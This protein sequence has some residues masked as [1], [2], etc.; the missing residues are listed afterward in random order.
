MTI[1]RYLLLTFT[2]C[3]I[4]SNYN[5][6]FGQTKI[7]V[8]PFPIETVFLHKI[9]NTVLI[10]QALNDESHNKLRE[11]NSKWQ[12]IRNQSQ[13][14]EE[15]LF[16][17]HILIDQRLPN[18]AYPKTEHA[19]LAISGYLSWNREL[20]RALKV[21]Q[22]EHKTNDILLEEIR[23]NLLLGN[24]QRVERNL[25]Q[26]SPKT[27]EEQLIRQIL[28]YWYLM[29]TGNIDRAEK[30]SQSIESEYL[31]SSQFN[32]HS[33]SFYD[34]AEEKVDLYQKA[35]TRFPSNEIIFE[36]LLKKLL[37]GRKYCDIQHLLKLQASIYHLKTD[38]QYL[39]N[40]IDKC[41]NQSSVEIKVDYTYLSWQAAQAL[42]KTQYNH[43]KQ[44]AEALIR[45]YPEYL[46]GQ[47]F[48]LEYYRETGQIELK[49][50]LQET[51]NLENQNHLN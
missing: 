21:L 12:K 17:N 24:Y 22:I 11:A 42:K 37:Q 30:V 34:K 1:S 47:L 9:E 49:Q 2:S 3:L 25:I 43:L 18:Q 13:K 39:N 40:M 23:L 50:K 44:Y 29:L 5:L 41:L 6:T 51:I 33:D 45:Y 48:L 27:K 31:Y 15:H 26:F 14:K 36:T 46:D 8:T 19:I 35:L 10:L 32:F 16:I 7:I 28:E 38:P 4:F 20:L